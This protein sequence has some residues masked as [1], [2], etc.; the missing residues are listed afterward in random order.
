M[1][2]SEYLNALQ[3]MIDKHGDMEIMSLREAYYNDEEDYYYDDVYNPCEMY[4]GYPKEVYLYEGYYATDLPYEEQKH[5]KVWL[6][7]ADEE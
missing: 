1:R 7:I 3:S 6:Y 4:I 2:L 5:T